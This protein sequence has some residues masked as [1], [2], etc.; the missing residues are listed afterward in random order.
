M[1]RKPRNMRRKPRN[2]SA[3]IAQAANEGGSAE[4]DLARDPKPDESKY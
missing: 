4:R 3:S 2:P 1:R